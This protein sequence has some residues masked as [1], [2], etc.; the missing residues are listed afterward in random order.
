LNLAEIGCDLWDKAGNTGKT[1][2]T[3]LHL[4]A[5]KEGDSH[6]R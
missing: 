3:Q 2:G 4:A 6:Q 1:A 5:A